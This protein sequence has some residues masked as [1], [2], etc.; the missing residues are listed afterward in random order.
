MEV[1][2]FLQKTP[3]SSDSNYFFPKAQALIQ[4]ITMNFIH[5]YNEN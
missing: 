1:Y 4:W 2:I 3:Q 5:E